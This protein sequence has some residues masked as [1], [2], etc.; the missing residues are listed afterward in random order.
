[1]SE[2]LDLKTISGTLQVLLDRAGKPVIYQCAASKQDLRFEPEN[3][4]TVNGLLPAFLTAADAVWH[5]ATG[6]RFTLDVAA[7]PNAIFGYVV[8]G[9]RSGSFST[10]M[11][12][13]MGV[14]AQI[15][16]PDCLLVNEL[17][18]VWIG[19][20]RRSAAV[21]SGAVPAAVAA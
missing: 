14:P 4:V 8:R 9:A 3:A 11:P 20:S 10:V 21:T 19:A 1:M 17:S 2:G 5:E 15:D 12:S 13:L 6:R 16:Q 18:T 7:D